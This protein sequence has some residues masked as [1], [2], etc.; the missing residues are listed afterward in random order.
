RR[1]EEE[2]NLTRQYVIES[3]VRPIREKIQ[4]KYS[5]QLKG[6]QLSTQEQQQIQQQIAE[7]LNAQTPDR[8]RQY[9]EREHQ[10]PAEVLAHQILQYLT[11]EQQLQRKFNK[12]YEHAMLSAKEIF[13]VGQ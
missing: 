11:Q 3:I 5:E 1:E 13:W 6:K 4:M 10:D 2:T 9:M 12:G 8:V 7:E